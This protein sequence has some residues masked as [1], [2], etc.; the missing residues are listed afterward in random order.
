[1]GHRTAPLGVEH[2][3]QTGT[4]NDLYRHFM[5]DADAIVSAANHLS[6]GRKIRLAKQI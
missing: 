6:A 5:I 2:F 1:M 3:G 4:I